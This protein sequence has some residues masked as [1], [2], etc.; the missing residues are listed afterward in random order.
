VLT[1]GRVVLEG[2]AKDLQSNRALIAAS[3]LGETGGEPDSAN[4][5]N[6]TTTQRI[7]A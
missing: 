4:N 6:T 5:G 1:H 2:P 3:Y 7:N